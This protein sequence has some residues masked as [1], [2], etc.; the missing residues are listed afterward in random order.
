MH[1]VARQTGGTELGLWE[2][3]KTTIGKRRYK[4]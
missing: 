4:G 3:V 1:H 2:V